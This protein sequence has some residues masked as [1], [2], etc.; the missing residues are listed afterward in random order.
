MLITGFVTREIRRVPLVIQELLILPKHLNSSP[1]FFV[2]VIFLQF[3]FRVLFCRSLFVLFSLFVWPL[4][5]CYLSF[6]DLQILITPVV[7]STSSFIT[8]AVIS[9]RSDLFV[10]ETCRTQRENN[11]PT[12]SKSNSQLKE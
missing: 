3:C 7:S 2:G 9:W 5:M 12:P 6:S 11:K 4:Y 8:I 10:E 1:C